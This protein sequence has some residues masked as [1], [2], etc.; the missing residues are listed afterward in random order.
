[1]T[2]ALQLLGALLVCAFI[3]A[4]FIDRLMKAHRIARSIAKRRRK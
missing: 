3:G 4:W 2:D 1:M